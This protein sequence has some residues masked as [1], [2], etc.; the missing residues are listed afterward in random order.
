[1]LHRYIKYFH[2]H[3]MCCATVLVSYCVSTSYTCMSTHTYIM[4]VVDTCA[5]TSA[6]IASLF[7]RMRSARLWTPP[8]GAKEEKDRRV[9]QE[10]YQ[11]VDKD[12][13]MSLS[14]F[15]PR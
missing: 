9:Y 10:T 12:R 14:I 3:H 7:R 8:P 11:R 4:L 6:T 15:L 2:L 13:Y 5:G 1:M